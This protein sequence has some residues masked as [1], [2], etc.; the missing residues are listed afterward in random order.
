MADARAMQTALLDQLGGLR[1]ELGDLLADAEIT[2]RRR[3][4][5]GFPGPRLD[6]DIPPAPRVLRGIELQ[7]LELGRVVLE[8]ERWFARNV[9]N[10]LRAAAAAMTR[11]T[12]LLDETDPGSQALTSRMQ[13]VI[14]KIRGRPA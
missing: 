4:G 8:L 12:G 3:A 2:F 11:L 10:Q 13:I 7:P 14:E 9:A 5:D 1:R 6:P